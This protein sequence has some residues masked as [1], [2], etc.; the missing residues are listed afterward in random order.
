[1]NNNNNELSNFEKTI[2]SFVTILGASAIYALFASFVIWIVTKFFGTPNMVMTQFIPCF[3]YLLL[4]C[5]GVIE[6]KMYT[7]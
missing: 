1:M 7:K 4:T 3:I 5:T 6:I 2:V